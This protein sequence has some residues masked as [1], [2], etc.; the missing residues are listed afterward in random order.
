[1]EPPVD[2]ICGIVTTISDR[3]AFFIQDEH[4]RRFYCYSPVP[5]SV[6]I[7]DIIFSPVKVINSDQLHIICSADSDD[8]NKSL[9]AVCI[10]KDRETLKR[11]FY[12]ALARMANGRKVAT[13][14]FD[15]LFDSHCG[16]SDA[17]I[18]TINGIADRSEMPLKEDVELLKP[19]PLKWVK[20]FARYW[21][22]TRLTRQLE[23]LGVDKDMR[24]RWGDK[25][26]TLI[27][28]CFK[29]P[30]RVYAIPNKVA[31]NIS[32]VFELSVADH[33]LSVIAG[34]IGCAISRLFYEMHWTS[35]PV[36]KVL[37]NI[38]QFGHPEI[39]SKII[40]PDLTTRSGLISCNDHLY[41]PQRYEVEEE[42]VPLIN[43]IFHLGNANIKYR[44]R[45]GAIKVTPEQKEAIDMALSR[46]FSIITGAA[47]TG[48]TTI[49]REVVSTL[50]SYE[51]KCLLTSLTGQATDKLKTLELEKLAENE[52]DVTLAHIHLLLAKRPKFES[53]F[54]IVIDE[55]SMVTSDIF[56]KFIKMIVSS[57]HEIPRILLVGDVNQL[58]PIGWGSFFYQMTK[59]QKI[60]K[61]YL[62]INHRSVKGILY[63]ANTVLSGEPFVPQEGF[64]ISKKDPIDV[65]RDLTP[66]LNVVDTVIITP[67]VKEVER[68]NLEI[69]KMRFGTSFHQDAR[70]DFGTSTDIPCIIDRSNN[71]W[72][73]GD[74]VVMRVN[75]DDLKN[76]SSGIIQSIDVVKNLL[77]I[78]FR[79]IDELKEFRVVVSIHDIDTTGLKS[80]ESEE[81]DP[82]I[83]ENEVLSSRHLILGYA[84]T[85]YR[86]QGSE[87]NKVIF[88]TIWHPRNAKFLTRNQVYT[89]LTRGK[90]KVVCT[91]SIRDLE[92]SKSCFSPERYDLLAYRIDNS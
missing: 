27:N 84:L 54:Y 31:K 22:T 30:Y 37:E 19:L 62:T 17:F 56:T 39:H 38:P 53:L 70:G 15:T 59:C 51:K 45:S 28:E 11:F 77:L 3:N 42:L 71:R 35:V 66:D 10:G 73:V 21:K 87:Y 2:K 92:M 50:L 33:E 57:N 29:N 12:K 76:G 34:D 58:E 91:G 16:D 20:Y 80:G 48:K 14:L 61:K 43:S 69:Q 79:G 63:N 32:S 49:I 52:D 4:S 88:H 40:N 90:T 67:Y 81:S 82:D 36:S 1:M 78:K 75:I 46:P 68:L 64:E 24:E 89:A 65:F 60:P 7:G 47:G 23:L 83:D 85:V 26:E 25:L 41:L 9:A 44:P 72:Y 6:D 74:L 5:M 13:K 86:A 55:A 8:N 18:R